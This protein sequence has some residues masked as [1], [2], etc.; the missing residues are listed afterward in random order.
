[1]DTLR[2]SIR[3]GGSYLKLLI[4]IAFS[5]LFV[6]R[7]A[8][9][10]DAVATDVRVSERDGKL[11]FVLDLSRE[12]GFRVFPL[13]RPYRM[14]I[15]LP[16]VGWRLPAQP[17]PRDRGVFRQM[18]YGL[19]QPGN[20]R[21]VLDLAGP[22]EVADAFLLP[23]GGER[24]YRLVIDL[25]GTDR[26]YYGETIDAPPLEVAGLDQHVN[27]RKAAPKGIDKT[28]E[29]ASAPARETPK[30]ADPGYPEP[31]EEA[32]PAALAKLLPLPPRRP[33]RRSPTQR[34]MIVLDPGHGGADPGTRGPSGTFEKH[35][36]LAMARE[37]K[38]QLEATGRYR[39]ALTRERDVFIRLRDRLAIARRREADVFISLHADS[40]RNPFIRGPS[41]YTLSEKASDKE[42]AELA[43]RENKSDL[44]AGVDLSHET[45]E[46]T[47][48]L[49]DLAQRE[50]MN[51]SSKFANILVKE[52]GRRTKVLPN[53]HRFAGF[54]VLKA[55]DVPSVLLETGFLSNKKDEKDLMSRKHRR[56][57]ATSII[58]ALDTY[59][60]VTEQ[61]TAQ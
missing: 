60:A 37:L 33:L 39:V 47:N 5:A 14:V 55:P 45:R 52:L 18:R 29:K 2:G 9:A 27:N 26:D 57:L 17:L 30:A 8:Q 1:M 22:V 54:A 21:V 41:V 50:T 59:F 31:T 43:E 56:K 36:V 19:F 15:D 12:V 34:P 6:I 48:I 25:A 13:A 7:P 23:P 53:P 20:S 16:E 11:R 24:P 44:I 35:I 10:V 28:V 61:A 42:A 40:I 3:T 46:V 38:T 32:L 4:F 58:E 49:I 51:Q